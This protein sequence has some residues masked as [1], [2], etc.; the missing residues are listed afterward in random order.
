MTTLKGSQFTLRPF[1]MSDLES[2]VEHINDRTIARYT[3]RIPYPY[4]SLDGKDF[5]R[6][7]TQ[8]H[9]KKESLIFAIAVEGEAVGGIGLHKIEK[10]HKAELGYWLGRE[11]W[12]QGMM[13]EAVHLVTTYAFEELHLKRVCAKVFPFNAASARVLEK[14]GYTYEGC[15][16]KNVMKN[17]KVL[18]ELVYA[19]VRS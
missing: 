12:G 10:R 5:L 14:A 2:L 7:Q 17:G 13:T 4:T 1:R 19:K 9:K 16:R 3:L 6:K 8:R 11:Y 18:D 15:L